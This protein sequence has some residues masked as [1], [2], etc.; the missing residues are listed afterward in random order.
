[1]S[2]TRVVSVVPSSELVLREFVSVP[3][4]SFG[5]ASEFLA[6]RL[7]KSE[8][9]ASGASPKDTL[10]AVF[11]GLRHSAR[12]LKTRRIGRQLNASR[13]VPELRLNALC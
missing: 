10:P 3:V 9:F 5:S 13:K 2:R 11:E 4:E 7:R 8:A 1:M 6:Y 12:R